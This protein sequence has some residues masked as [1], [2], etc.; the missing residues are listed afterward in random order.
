MNACRSSGG[1]KQSSWNLYEPCSCWYKMQCMSCSGYIVRRSMTPPVGETYQLLPKVEE[2]LRLTPSV[3]LGGGYYKVL[4][5]H[6]EC[7]SDR[8]ITGL[9]QSQ[10]TY[11]Y[12]AKEDELVAYL[13]HP[14]LSHQLRSSAADSSSCSKGSFCKRF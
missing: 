9:R 5:P 3:A 11:L 7:K 14:K 13:N 8:P 1:A 6:E 10:R 4:N 12:K 2:V